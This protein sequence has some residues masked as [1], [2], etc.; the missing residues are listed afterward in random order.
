MWAVDSETGSW[1]S[2]ETALKSTSCTASAAKT[3]QL[4]RRR[5]SRSC[6]RLAPSSTARSTPTGTSAPS[7]ISARRHQGAG[8]RPE[9]LVQGV[10]LR[11][12]GDLVPECTDDLRLD[13]GRALGHAHAVEARDDA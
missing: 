7:S 6:L 11:N 4:A 13:L 12:R 2:R 3:T 5:T 1:R 8:V 9:L 10:K